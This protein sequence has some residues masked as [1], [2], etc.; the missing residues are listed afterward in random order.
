[1]HKVLLNGADGK[2]GA[3]IKDIITANPEYNL[4]I[5]CLRT[6]NK[7]PVCDEFD[8]IIDFSSPEGVAEMYQ[9]ALKNKKPFLSG[10]TGLPEDLLNKLKAETQIPLFYAPNVSISV[11]YFAELVKLARKF[12]T[13]YDISMH[14]EHHVQKKDAPSGTAKSLAQLLDFPPENISCKRE[15]EITGTHEVSFFSPLEEISLVHKAKDRKLFA[16][17]AVVVASWLVSKSAGF[18]TMKDF[19]NER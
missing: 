12:Y 10:V 6:L 3:M 14:E 16:Q 5:C 11:Y 1:M 8:I 13:G 2:M 17:S 7:E 15:G 19:V 4:Q 18:Y 9:L